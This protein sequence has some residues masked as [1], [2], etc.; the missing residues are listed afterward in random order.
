LLFDAAPVRFQD[1]ARSKTPGERRTD[2]RDIEQIEIDL[3]EKVS[4]IVTG[5]RADRSPIRESGRRPAPAAATG[6]SLAR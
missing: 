1:R 3:G 6:V 2:Q 4:E 5:L